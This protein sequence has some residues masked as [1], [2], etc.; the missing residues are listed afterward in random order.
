M[1]W[2]IAAMKSV[3]ESAAKLPPCFGEPDR[4]PEILGQ[5]LV[6]DPAEVFEQCPVKLEVGPEHLGQGQDPVAMGGP[7]RAPRRRET[8][9]RTAPSSGGRRGKPACLARE[10]HEELMAAFRAAHAGETL[11]EIAALEKLAD[12]LGD[13]V[14]EDAV[15]G[16]VALG[17]DLEKLLEMGVDAAPERRS[18]RVAGLV[19]L[20]RH[21]AQCRKE[22]VP[23][24]GT[25]PKKSEESEGC[26]P[27]PVLPDQ[28]H[29]GHGLCR[30]L[31]TQPQRLPAAHSA[32]KTRTVLAALSLPTTRENMNGK[33][34][35]LFK[36]ARSRPKRF[37]SHKV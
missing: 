9:R 4:A 36:T 19:D 37:R 24:N 30:G 27:P 3:G 6:S 34:T 32:P 17:I 13:H 25:D 33:H 20:L 31:P 1:C 2:V 14:A 11:F 7:G 26:L 23:S 35:A 12:H 22:P 15:A 16:L 21:T 18:F 29:R 8:P 28:A 5:A 10:R